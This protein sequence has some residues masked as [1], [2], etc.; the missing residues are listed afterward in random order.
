MI[1]PLIP[2]LYNTEYLLNSEQLRQS[3]VIKYAPFKGKVVFE[4]PVLG[5]VNIY[6]FSL[7]L[8]VLVLIPVNMV[9]RKVDMG[10]KLRGANHP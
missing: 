6:I 10:Y 9:L 3:Y 1:W 7:L 5:D 4:R 2:E 8:F